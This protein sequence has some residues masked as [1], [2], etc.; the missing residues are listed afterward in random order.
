MFPWCWTCPGKGPGQIQW[1]DSERHQ[2]WP[3]NPPQKSPKPALGSPWLIQRDGRE[4]P[5]LNPDSRKILLGEKTAP[6]PKCCLSSV[7]ET[8]PAPPGA[9]LVCQGPPGCSDSP[10]TSTGS[11]TSSLL[12]SS[13][14]LSHCA[15]GELQIRGG[16]MLESSTET[17]SRIPHRGI[18]PSRCSALGSL[19]SSWAG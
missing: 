17:P 4:S 15:P 14:A 11:E 8:L 13:T 1:Q 16:R 6:A 2:T 19:P 10:E 18:V 12:P 3:P 7:A 9:P 5:G